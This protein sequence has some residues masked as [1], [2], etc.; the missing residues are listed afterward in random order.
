[1]AASHRFLLSSITDAAMRR[2]GRK[3]TPVLR[4]RVGMRTSQGIFGR[5][6]APDP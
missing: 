2:C 6:F 1:L 3:D 5:D 4:A